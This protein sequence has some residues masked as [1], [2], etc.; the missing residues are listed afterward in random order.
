MASRTV[1]VRVASGAS[2]KG[3]PPSKIACICRAVAWSSAAPA[4]STAAGTGL[5]AARRHACQSRKEISRHS[6]AV[7]RQPASSST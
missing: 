3:A 2:V 1:S 5:P 4:A 7:Q 6:G